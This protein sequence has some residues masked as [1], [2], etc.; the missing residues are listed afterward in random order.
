VRKDLVAERCDKIAQNQLKY[1]RTVSVE[2]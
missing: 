1:T 2:K